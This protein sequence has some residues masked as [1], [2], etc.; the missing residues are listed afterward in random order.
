VEGVECLLVFGISKPITNPAA[1]L[2]PSST[3]PAARAEDH[4][5]ITNKRRAQS[6][7]ANF[8]G[9]AAV[10]RRAAG[11]RHGGVYAGNP[12]RLEGLDP[13]FTLFLVVDRIGVPHRWVSCSELVVVRSASSF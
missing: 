5:I 8:S 1:S 6:G 2:H 3:T 10:L 11:P 7:W 9:A 13:P 4:S 12:A